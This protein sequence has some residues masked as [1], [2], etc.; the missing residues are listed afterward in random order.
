MLREI[1]HLSSFGSVV[2]STHLSKLFSDAKIKLN[3]YAHTR[4][5]VWNAAKNSWEEIRTEIGDEV[6][7]NFVY[8]A[9]AALDVSLA[10]AKALLGLGLS[11]ETTKSIKDTCDDICGSLTTFKVYVEDNLLCNKKKRRNKKRSK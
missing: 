3:L 8:N 5:K 4:Q 11:K 10:E 2:G 7:D 9:N 6:N 1:E